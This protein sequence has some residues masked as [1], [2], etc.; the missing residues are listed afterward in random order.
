MNLNFIKYK[1]FMTKIFIKELNRQ[2]QLLVNFKI[3]NQKMT[4]LNYILLSYKEM[5]FICKI[6]FLIFLIDR[7]KILRYIILMIIMIRIYRMEKLELC[8]F[9]PIT[10]K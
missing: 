6:I 7:N 3:I 2:K 4:N 1:Q 9:I 5:K 8:L 10:I